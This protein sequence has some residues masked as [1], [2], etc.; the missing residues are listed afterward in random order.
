MQDGRPRR[1]VVTLAVVAEGGLGLLAWALGW[2]IGQPPLES[3]RWDWNDAALGVGATIPPLLMLAI[4]IRWPIRPIVRIRRFCDAVIRPLFQ[5]CSL[6]DLAVISALAGIGEEMLFRGVI[7]AGFSR[8]LGRW[9]GVA[10]GSALFGLAHP[11]TPTYALWAGLM[12]MY[13]GSLWIAT[14]N[15]L[16]VIIAHAVYDLVAL[17]YL[18]RSDAVPMAG[19][20]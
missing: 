6:F 9:G 15:L 11:I 16:I 8:W 7:Q 18:V 14:G 10:A 1:H 20:V 5:D 2:L 17:W 3:F 19:T 13:L 12:G 4:A